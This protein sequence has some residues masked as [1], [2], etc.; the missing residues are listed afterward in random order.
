MKVASSIA[1]ALAAFLALD[2]LVYNLTAYEHAGGSMLLILAFT[3]A[4]LGFVLRG[5][6]RKA[7]R[8]LAQEAGGAEKE[9]PA[10]LEHVGP[11]IWPFGFS[12]AAL[13][14]VVG[15]VID[16]KVITAVG[17]A[18]FAGS[19]VGWFLDVRRQ[20]GHASH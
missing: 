13:G 15:V 20:H 16:A 6:A 8:A 1:L 14:L 11:T 5:A 9:G 2:G 10:E 17:A 19:S 12:L 18:L 7:E 4:Y 3:F